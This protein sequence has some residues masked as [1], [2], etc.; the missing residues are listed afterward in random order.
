MVYGYFLIG[1]VYSIHWLIQYEAYVFE[2]IETMDNGLKEDE[3]SFAH[4]VFTSTMF[5]TLVLIWP[6]R[7]YRDLKEF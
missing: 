1:A 7:A 5:A 2:L 4:V 6:Y 3:L